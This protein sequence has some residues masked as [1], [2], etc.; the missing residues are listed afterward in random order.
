MDSLTNGYF[1]YR[2]LWV[3]FQ[4][5]AICAQVSDHGIEETLTNIPPDID[6]T[7]ERILEMINK[8]PAAQRELAR[9]ALLFIAY[10]RA[11]ASIDVL[12]LAIAASTAR[13]YTQGLDT[14]R[15]SISTEETILQACGNLLSIDNTNRN[16]RRACFVHFSVH[17]FVTSKRSALLNTMSFGY[18]IGN[19]EIARTCMIFLLISYSQIHGYCTFT[20]R[21]FANWYILPELPHHL[22]AGNLNSLASSDEM[23]CLTS[24]FFAR[25]PPLL[26]PRG[27]ADKSYMNFYTFSP[28][29]L[30]LIFNLPVPYRHL[31]S[32]E[33]YGNK[34]DERGLSWIHG[35]FVQVSDD[36]FAIHYAIGRLN[37]IAVAERLYNDGHPIDYSYC[38]SNGPLKTSNT[39]AEHQLV[40]DVCRLTPLYLVECE[41]AARFLLNRGA[42]MNPPIANDGVNGGVPNLL[43]HVAK[44]GNT[45]VIQLLLDHGAEQE[46][47]AQCSTLQSLAYHGHVEALQLLLGHGADINSQGGKYGNALNAAAYIGRVESMQLLLDHGADVNAQG[48]EHGNALQVAAYTGQVECMQLLLDNGADVNVHGGNH[49]NALQA[50]AFM[51]RLECMRLLLDNGADVNAHGEKYGNALQAAAV[52]GRVEAMQLLLDNGADVNAQGGSYCSALGAAVFFGRVEAESFLRDR[53]AC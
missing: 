44:R 23:V 40:P 41:G 33:V 47:E 14:L 1:E 13:C 43:G 27:L 19:R 28:P 2:F 3:E 20:E 26:A 35:Y 7:Y 36:R 37:S 9:K 22:L 18:E 12:A 46:K 15:S 38:D 39:L 16:F 31:N 34:F 24:L 10:A 51:G 52:M 32:P 30:A 42:R 50:A 48:G 5:K 6:T 21:L 49:G 53:G 25:G 8:K 4:L 29:V 17:E 11:P 45:K